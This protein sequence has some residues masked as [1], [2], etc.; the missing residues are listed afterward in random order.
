MKHIKM[1][2][3]VWKKV[4][5]CFRKELYLWMR[6][7]ILDTFQL[8]SE[9]WFSWLPLHKYLQCVMFKRITMCLNNV[10]KSWSRCLTLCLETPSSTCLLFMYINCDCTHKICFCYLTT[11]YIL[12]KIY[13]AVVY[14]RTGKI[15]TYLNSF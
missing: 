5:D 8:P 14:N 11:I 6:K 12:K 10:L 15:K 1:S 2:S 3:T 7:F 13:Q 4:I 9:S